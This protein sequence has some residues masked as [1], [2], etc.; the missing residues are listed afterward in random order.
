MIP[1]GPSVVLSHLGWFLVAPH[2]PKGSEAPLRG[3]WATGDGTSA[4]LALQS[5]SFACPLPLNTYIYIV[6][7]IKDC[8]FP[9][10]GINVP[11]RDIKSDYCNNM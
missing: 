11:Y 5:N 9:Y 7:E 8:P 6:N 1:R 3:P 2:G 4:F 10:M